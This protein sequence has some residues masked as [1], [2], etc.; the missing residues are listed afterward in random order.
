MAA[1]VVLNLIGKKSEFRLT[2]PSNKELFVEIYK[3]FERFIGFRISGE[4]L[5]V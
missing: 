3:E 4:I 1:C 2:Q 5:K